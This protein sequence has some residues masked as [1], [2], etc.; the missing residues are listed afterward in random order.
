MI[1]RWIRELVLYG[2]QT[3][4]VESADEI[5]VTNRLLELFEVMEY[6][7]SGDVEKI[8]PLQE[9]LNDMLSYALENSILKE[10]TIT[11]K[12][13]FDTKIMGCI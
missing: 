2:K 1:T 5:Y 6:E 13:L 9:I 4:L 10:D 7:E 12:D 8:R 3:G 11:A